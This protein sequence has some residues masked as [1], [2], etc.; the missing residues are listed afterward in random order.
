M[1]RSY[2]TN[3]YIY[4]CW[5]V[6]SIFV[7][8]DTDEEREQTIQK[9]HLKYKG[10]FQKIMPY[11]NINWKTLYTFKIINA[12]KRFNENWSKDSKQFEKDVNTKRNN[13]STVFWETQETDKN[14]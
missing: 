1:I 13:S 6:P 11:K 5:F 9:W 10:I 3:E 2:N 8:C 4:W 12:K 7:S 14:I